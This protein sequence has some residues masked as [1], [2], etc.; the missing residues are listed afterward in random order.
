MNCVFF[1]LCD[2]GLKT[3]EFKKIDVT[4]PPAAFFPKH[5]NNKQANN[6]SL[7]TIVQIGTIGLLLSLIFSL[8]F[9]LSNRKLT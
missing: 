6:L 5:S 2:P 7:W 9:N 8:I 3:I 4:C 1:Q